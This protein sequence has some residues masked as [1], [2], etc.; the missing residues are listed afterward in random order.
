MEPFLSIGELLKVKGEHVTCAFPEQFR[1]LA[2]DSGLEFA[3]LGK[4]YIELMESDAGKVAFGG[5]ATGIKKMMAYFKMTRKSTTINRELCRRQYDIIERERPDR[6]VYNSKA[7]VPVLWGLDHPGRIILVSSVPFMHYVKDHSHVVFHRNF[8]PFLNRLTYSLADFGLATTV[9]ITKRWLKL[10]HGITRRKIRNVLSSRK[11]IYTV[12]P[13]LF[14]RPVYWN[15]NLKVLGYR[16]RTK[17]TDWKPD[18]ELTVFI[19]K[20]NK[21]L[22]FTFGSMTNPEPEEKTRVIVDILRRNSIPAIIN[23]A[24]GGLVRSA[25]FDP[26]L[27]HFVRQIPY[28]WIFPRVYGIIHH[29]GSGTTHLGLKYGC[30]TMIIPHIIDQF[31]WDD[32]VKSMGAGPEGLGIS[33]ISSGNLEP[34]ILELMSNAAY[35]KKAEEIAGQMEKEDFNEEMYRSIVE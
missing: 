22:F 30:A 26:E 5:S 27:I 29:G 4:A 21:I 11:V 25:A 15:E 16:E 33:K 28:D 13:T 8:G 1:K 23:T 35:K 17:T 6:I 9:M 3:S 12:S 32:I 20:H 19:K 7:T 31:V 24:S 34:R 14:Q 2:E 18:G 10:K